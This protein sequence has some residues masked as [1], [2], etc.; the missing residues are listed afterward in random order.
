MMKPLY[1]LPSQRDQL[2]IVLLLSLFVAVQVSSLGRVATAAEPAREFLNGLRERGYHDIALD[3]L[4]M[5]ET[6]PLAPA[7]LKEIIQYEKGVTLIEGSRAQRDQAIREKFLDDAQKLLKDFTDNPRTAQHAL[8]NSARNQLGN[9]IVERARMKVERSKKG[10][11]AKLLKK[12]LQNI[13]TY[14][15]HPITNAL[16][17][18]LNS[19]IQWVKYTARG[20]RNLDNFK[21]A[22][23]FHCGGLDLLPAT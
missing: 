3:Y 18:S 7:E 20:F 9:L 2:G 15:T 19:K 1:T 8:A 22:I 21:T 13:L 16:S 17:E 11:K 4:A 23:Y 14:L 6:S 12:H 10:D 5:M